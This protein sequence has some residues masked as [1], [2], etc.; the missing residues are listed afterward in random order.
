[1]ILIFKTITKIKLKAAMVVRWI[2]GPKRILYCF[3]V[4]V[5]WWN[6]LLN[7]SSNIF[8]RVSFGPVKC[9]EKFLG[10]ETDKGNA[11]LRE[12]RGGQIEI[13]FILLPLIFRSV[14]EY[15]YSTLIGFLKLDYRFL[16]C[17]PFSNKHFQFCY[18]FYTSKSDKMRLIF[19][20]MLMF[21]LYHDC[22]YNMFI[23]Q[24]NGYL[25][26]GV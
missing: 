17:Y 23:Q 25:I 24:E 20:T 9:Q 26:S 21:L 10:P 18:C 5:I 6:L 12:F 16:G 19:M 8:S 4:T 13:K 3:S 7:S 15:F 14:F 1:M 2:Q 22:F 11:T